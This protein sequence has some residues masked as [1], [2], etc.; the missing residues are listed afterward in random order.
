MIKPQL[1]WLRTA[2]YQTGLDVKMEVTK[3][4]VHVVLK[5]R[6]PGVLHLYSLFTCLY[7]LGVVS[8]LGLG[9][10]LYD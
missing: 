6:H 8:V 7:S 5:A 4:A 10:L 1:P 9:L 2:I 3:C